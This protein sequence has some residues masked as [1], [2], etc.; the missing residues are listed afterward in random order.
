M[1]TGND[2]SA[3]STAGGCKGK[4]ADLAQ[5]KGPEAELQKQQKE[6][7]GDQEPSAVT[8]AGSSTSG[9]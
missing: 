6:C 4:C 1:C 7:H 9:E 8:L 2:K 3:G 5:A